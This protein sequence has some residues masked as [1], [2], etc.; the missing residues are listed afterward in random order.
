M[1]LWWWLYYNK[2]IAP[3]T[4][5]ICSSYLRKI[6]ENYEKRSFYSNK[7]IKRPLTSDPIY[8]INGGYGFEIIN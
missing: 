4:G 5:D 6:A 2:Q 1:T 3:I 8:Y 7:P